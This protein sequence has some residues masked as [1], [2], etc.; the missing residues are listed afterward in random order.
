M[1]CNMFWTFLEL[2]KRSPSLLPSTPYLLPKYF[3]RIKKMNKSFQTSYSRIS[4]PFVNPKCA[5]FWKVRDTTVLT[6]IFLMGP[7]QLVSTIVL[8]KNGKYDGGILVN[9]E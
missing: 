7:K 4:H 2:S 3:K 9:L 1:G 5:T 8:N 6:I